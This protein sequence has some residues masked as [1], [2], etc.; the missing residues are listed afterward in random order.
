MEIALPVTGF[1][2]IVLAKLRCLWRGPCVTCAYNDPHVQLAAPEDFEEW[3][4]TDSQKTLPPPP[5]PV[6]RVLNLRNLPRSD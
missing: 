5:L 3:T 2:T 6:H 4:P 1:L